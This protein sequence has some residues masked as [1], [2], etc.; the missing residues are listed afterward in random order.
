[1]KTTSICVL[2]MKSLH[3]FFPEEEFFSLSKDIMVFITHHWKIL[4]TQKQFQK[5]NWRKGILDSFNHCPAIESGIEHLNKRGFYR[6]K[7]I[8][9]KNCKLE[10]YEDKYQQPRMKQIPFVQFQI[11]KET[12]MNQYQ[13]DE[14]MEQELGMM[15]LKDEIK[16]SLQSLVDQMNETQGDRKSVV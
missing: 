12:A 10:G 14:Q 7:P 11:N 15:T 1:M 3:K 5:E 16:Y 13:K 8:E 4:S 6:L 9:I 2:I